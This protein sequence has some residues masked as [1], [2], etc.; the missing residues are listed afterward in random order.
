MMTHKIGLATVSL[1]ISAVIYV[2]AALLLLGIPFFTE[3]EPEFQEAFGP[4]FLGIMVAMG[5][6]SAIGVEVVARGISKRKFWAWVAGLCIFA[7]YLPSLFLPLSAFG[8]YGLLA[9]GSRAEFGIGVAT[10][11]RANRAVNTDAA[12]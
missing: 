2:L 8:L 3:N 4:V 7:L 5:L 1:H 10:L 12:R 6:A 9:A 11:K